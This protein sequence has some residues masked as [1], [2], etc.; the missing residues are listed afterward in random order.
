MVART[1]GRRGWR[2]RSSTKCLTRFNI[3]WTWDGGDAILMSRATDSTG[4]VQPSI[5]ELRKVRGTKSIYH[6]NSIQ[7]WLVSANGEV[8]NVQVG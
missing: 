4:H 7:S 8:S 6:N 1:G 2:H 3:D 5:T